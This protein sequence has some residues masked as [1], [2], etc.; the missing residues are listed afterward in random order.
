MKALMV[1]SCLITTSVLGW[2]G[3]DIARGY[4][5]PNYELQAQ[6][7]HYFVGQDYS[8]IRIGALRSKG[9]YVYKTEANSETLT[10]EID[11]SNPCFTTFETEDGLVTNMT[12]KGKCLKD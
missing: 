7:R 3:T 1:I 8:D 12:M 6:G 11:K 4:L 10:Y 2:I 9:T 5:N